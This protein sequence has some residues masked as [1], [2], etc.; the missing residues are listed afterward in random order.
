MSGAF[1]KRRASGREASERRGR[2]GVA[3]AAAL[4]HEG[5]D[6]FFLA[7]GVGWGSGS[8][9]IGSSSGFRQ[10][11]QQHTPPPIMNAVKQIV[12]SSWPNDVGSI[13]LTRL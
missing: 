8:A 1:V 11:T 7:L 12:Y 10:R 6:A 9:T 13:W 4:R 5:L 3:L 2:G